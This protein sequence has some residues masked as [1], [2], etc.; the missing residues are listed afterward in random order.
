MQFIY[1]LFPLS[2][3]LVKCVFPTSMNNMPNPNTLLLQATQE[4]ALEALEQLNNMVSGQE[5]RPWELS[6]NTPRLKY[7]LAALPPQVRWK[8]YRVYHA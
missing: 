5:F 3:T 8:L 6:D 2:L 4:H 7:D 1:K